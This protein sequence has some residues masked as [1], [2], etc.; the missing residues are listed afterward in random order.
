MKKISLILTLFLAVAI[1]GYANNSDVNVNADVLTEQF[2]A[3][4]ANLM[5]DASSD[6]YMSFEEDAGECCEV[7]CTVTVKLVIVDISASWCCVKC[8]D[9]GTAPQ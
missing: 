8:K 5:L 3:D 6:N 4:Q 2:A 9:P 1:S 7:T